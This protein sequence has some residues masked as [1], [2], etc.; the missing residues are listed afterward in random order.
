[1]RTLWLCLILMTGIMRAEGEIKVNPPE[2]EYESIAGFVLT[3]PGPVDEMPGA[4]LPVMSNLETGEQIETEMYW[5]GLDANQ[6]GLRLPFELDFGG[7]W[8]LVIFGSTFRVNRTPIEEEHRFD[9]R[10]PEKDAVALTP[11]DT[12]Q[13]KWFRLDGVEC[14]SPL[15]GIYIRV[16]KGKKSKILIK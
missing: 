10:L 2:G 8:Q 11:C 1:M 12:S 13:T 6:Y 5:R 9:Y 15:K 14:P 4:R 7:K 16:D 3:F